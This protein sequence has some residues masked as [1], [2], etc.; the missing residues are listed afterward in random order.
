MFVL[1]GWLIWMGP[2][3]SLSGRHTA[4]SGNPRQGLEGKAENGGRT[5]PGLLAVVFI[6]FSLNPVYNQ[7][8][9][10]EFSGD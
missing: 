8:G 6:W 9:S 3:S 2:P 10:N 7:V 1:L 4:V 5:G